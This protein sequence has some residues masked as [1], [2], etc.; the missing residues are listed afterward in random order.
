ME[1]TV[2]KKEPSTSGIAIKQEIKEE[3]DD[4]D[5]CIFYDDF[6]VKKESEDNFDEVKQA[7]MKFEATDLFL[8]QGSK[9]DDSVEE[10]N[11]IKE[12]GML[13]TKIE[14]GYPHV[15]DDASG[16][17]KSFECDIC[18]KKYQ[19]K[20]GLFNHKKYFHEKHVLE[21]FKCDKCDYVTVRESTLKLHLKIHDKQSYLKCHYCQYMAAKLT[22]L[23]AH[24]LIKHKKENEKD[25]KIKITS[26]IHNCPNCSYSNV[27]KSHYNNH[28]TKCLKLKNF[29]YYECHLCDHKTTHK[30]HLA[31]H[32][33]THNKIKEF[34][35]LF[36]T[37]QC[38]VKQN[39]DNHMLTKHSNLL[40]ESNKNII[41][42]KI[43]YCQH[44]NYKTANRIH[45]KSHFRHKHP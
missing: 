41:T 8:D 30:N 33:K 10:S 18:P 14:V 13:E 36:C 12:E 38:N 24:I 31:T 19:T 34:K 7:E 29:E 22:T 5:N 15:D 42:S 28:I 40:N 1:Q 39:L 37:H 35:C 2:V 27:S 9:I 11:N 45:L 21:K 26:K 6:G 23:H 16:K 32:I 20:T 25:N 4:S 44:C 43:H 17:E 3:F